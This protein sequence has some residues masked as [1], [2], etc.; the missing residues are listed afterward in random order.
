MSTVK[1]KVDLQ[2]VEDFLQH[3]YR[4]DKVALEVIADGEIS[5]AYFF[6]VSGQQK[7][8]RINAKTDEGFQ[9]DIYATKHFKSDQL[10]IPTIDEIGQLDNGMYFAVSERTPGKTLDR[11]S[12]DELVSL[13]PEIIATADAIHKIEPKGEGYGWFKID[14][15]A[16][17]K[18]WHEALDNLQASEDDNSLP[19]ISFFE[20]DYYQGLQAKIK[21][22]YQYIPN[23]VRH[24]VHGDYG[25]GNTLSDGKMITGVI[26]WHDGRYGDPLWDV[27]WLDFWGDQVGFA[28]A[29]RQHYDDQGRLPDNFDERIQCYKLITGSTGLAFFAKSG[30]QEKYEHAKKILGEIKG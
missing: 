23:D 9:K 29:F 27:A 5:Q 21:D 25:F 6:E 12:A 16:P 17:C 14:G 26:D 24:L 7:V 30:Q 19:D 13:L 3:H 11:F 22:L 20:M 10:P 18:S 28:A 8:L 15:T 1:T 2:L 4:L